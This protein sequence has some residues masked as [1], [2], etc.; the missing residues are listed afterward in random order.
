M[1][2][3]NHYNFIKNKIILEKRNVFLSGPGGTGKSYLAKKLFAEL[4]CENTIKINKHLHNNSENYNEPNNSTINSEILEV[5]N[6]YIVKIGATTGA[7]SLLI[8]GRT[9]HSILGIGLGTESVEYYVNRICKNKVMYSLWTAP[10]LLLIFDE[11]SM[12]GGSLFKK[13]NEIGKK[14]RRNPSQFMGGIQLLF[15]GDFYQLPPVKDTFIFLESCW[16]EAKFYMYEMNI[17][18]RYNNTAF[19]DML[20]RI[21]EQCITPEDITIIKKRLIN[22]EQ[23]K[24]LTNGQ[25]IE[26][27]TEHL[28]SEPLTNQNELNQNELNQNEF[29]NSSDSKVCSICLEPMNERNSIFIQCMH[30]YHKKCLRTLIEN[31]NIPENLQRSNSND[32]LVNCPDCR[33]PIG[34]CIVSEL[35]NNENQEIINESL[36]NFTII[37]TILYSCKKDTSMYNQ[38]ELDKLQT[39]SVTYHSKDQIYRKDRFG[40]KIYDSIRDPKKYETLLDQFEKNN[41]KKC[42]TLKVG[43]QVML[44]CNMS[45][46]QGLV[47]GSR[48]VVTACEP[49]SISVLFKNQTEPVKIETHEFSTVTNDNE[50]NGGFAK[51]HKKSTLYV[52]RTQFP[53]ILGWAHTIHSIQGS[54]LDACVLDI[55]DSVF[56]YGQAYVALSRCKDLNSVYLVNFNET[57]VMAHPDVLKFYNEL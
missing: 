50:K 5:P 36:V 56:E 41:I 55:G 37:P 18:Y 28:S 26:M 24:K 1:S 31:S 12:L 46:D 49:E 43:A 6:E 17:P 19:F 34:A 15:I 2:D 23:F 33:N 8:E 30:Q 57:K 11:I 13:L 25:R 53:L 51:I 32:N 20:M 40:T 14:V 22:K 39:N 38:K 10:K 44:K 47:N 35:I 27:N 7:A 54:T 42:L 16:D 4:N 45:P 48:G 3:E 9:L 52:C 29:N 21:R